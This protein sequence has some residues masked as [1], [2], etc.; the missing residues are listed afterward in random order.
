MSHRLHRPHG[1]PQPPEKFALLFRPRLHIGASN[2]VMALSPPFH[3]LRFMSSRFIMI[4]G[5]IIIFLPAL[6]ESICYESRYAR[7]AMERVSEE[8]TYAEATWQA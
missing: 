3:S 2:S 1:P 5:Y 6:S 4:F 8:A 7:V